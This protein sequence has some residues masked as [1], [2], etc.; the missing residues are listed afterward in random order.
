VLRWAGRLFRREWRQQLLV[1]VLL[2]VAV[3][4]AVA[5]SAVAVNAASTS[6]GEFGNASALIRVAARDAASAQAAVAAARQRYGTVDAVAH[7]S[8]AVP[9]STERLDVR[10]QD[11]DGAYGGPM[12]HLRDGRYPRAGGE[13]ALTHRA[14]ELF[15]AE[16]GS[17]IDLDRHPATVVGIVENPAQLSDDFALVAPGT[18]TGAQAYAVLVDADQRSGTATTTSDASSSLE[19]FGSS[20]NRSAIIATV[21]A[22]VTLGMALVGL[23]AAAGFLVV[24]QRRQRQIGL[25]SAI[26]ASDRHVRLVMVANGAIVGVLATL[27]GTAMGIT[28]WIL[29]APAV[30]S[31]AG[32]RIGRFDLPW[33]LIVAVMVLAIA[34]ATAAAWWPARVMA[35]LSVIA[36]LSGRPASP[37]PVHRSLLVAALFVAGGV[38][39]ISFAHPKSE[40]VQPL[41]LI[42]GVLAV[43]V[44]A[45]FATPAAIRFLGSLARRAPLAPRLALRDLARYQARAAA[46]LAAITLGLG[47]SVAVV[48]IAAANQPPPDAGNLSD[49]ELL[50]RVG[51]VRKEVDP[52][53]AAA[54]LADLDHRAAT[55]VAALGEGYHSVP[56]DTAVSVD[57]QSGRDGPV[58]LG[59]QIDANTIRMDRGLPYVATPD[60]LAE[61]GID[62]AGIDDDTDVLTVAHR[63]LLLLAG[64]EPPARGAPPAAAQRVDLPPYS[65]APNSL[66]T[67]AAVRRHGWSTTRAA[68]IV[69]SSHPLS[70]AQVAA[71]RAAAA[72]VGLQVESRTSDDWSLSLRRGATL[73]G[74]VL[75]LAIVAMA[76][77]LIRGESA[78]ELRT[79]TASGAAPRTRRALTATTAGALAAVGVVLGIAG[80]YIALVAAYWSHLD[81]LVPLPV[82]NLLWLLLGLPVV[83][84]AAGWAFAGREPRA[85]ARQALE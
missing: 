47:I 13:V 59:E 6:R 35:R 42:A 2:T 72:K 25:V 64:D 16:I 3:G 58:S 46:A 41:L 19:L 77:G 5:G 26:G 34:V 14:A 28:G 54:A 52:A 24:A 23:V 76:V 8:A 75:A 33:T 68:W 17:T 65:S 7:M 82:D 44:G 79:L 20:S 45:V 38:T 70:A 61:Y 15:G 84:T 4:A 73:V 22:A 57:P 9:G 62:E 83:A 21:L 69:E 67:P 39:A 10:D 55:V 36:A 63:P 51:E 31:A 27:V 1:L 49:R 74:G 37:R 11:P 53:S 18:L 48:G 80:A 40:H 78:S 30:E 56:L 50:V 29:S 85:I 32:H 60:V 66:I 81:E 12:L 71:A 43:V